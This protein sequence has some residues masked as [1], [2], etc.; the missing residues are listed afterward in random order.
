MASRGMALGTSTTLFTV[1]SPLK[2]LAIMPAVSTSLR[3]PR[4]PSAR[5]TLYLSIFSFGRGF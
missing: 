1:S 3:S 4:S 5:N 2:Y